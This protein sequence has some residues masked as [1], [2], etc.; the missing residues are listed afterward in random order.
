MA[1]ELQAPGEAAS[2]A[3]VFTRLSDSLEVWQVK[4]KGCLWD[5]MLQGVGC[6]LLAPLQWDELVMHQ[7]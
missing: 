4:L 2:D 5:V 7:G 3:R 6:L 1:I